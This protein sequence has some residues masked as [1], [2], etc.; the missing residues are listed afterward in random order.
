MTCECTPGQGTEPNPYSRGQ[1]AP[2]T[3]GIPGKPFD[4]GLLVK[5]FSTARKWMR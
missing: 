4:V 5:Q 3:P 1:E 2:G